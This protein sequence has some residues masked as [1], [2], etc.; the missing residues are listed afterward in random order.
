[1]KLVFPSVGH[2][3]TSINKSKGGPGSPYSHGS[4]NLGIKIRKG[5]HAFVGN[6]LLVNKLNIFLHSMISVV[7]RARLHPVT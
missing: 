1:M 7:G 4:I 2:L 3:L 5:T 6:S